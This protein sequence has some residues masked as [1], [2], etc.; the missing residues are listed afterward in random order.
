MPS[1]EPV[2]VA[3]DITT[4]V[5]TLV[6]E[7]QGLI[8]SDP[9]RLLQ[10]AREAHE[11]ARSIGDASLLGR[12][13]YWI[14]I[15]FRQA[16]DLVNA[17]LFLRQANAQLFAAYD[18]EYQARALQAIGT[19]HSASGELAEAQEC[20]VR[21]LSIARDRNDTYT[22][23]R[24][25]NSWGIVAIRSADY[26]KAFELYE[27]CLTYLRVEPDPYM[28]ASILSNIGAIYQR[29]G[30]YALAID[31]CRRALAVQGRRDDYRQ[32]A[33]V[34]IM[35]ADTLCYTGEWTEAKDAISKAI[36]IAKQHD[37]VDIEAIA[38]RTLVDIAKHAGDDT[39]S[40]ELLEE[41][42]VLSQ[43]TGNTIYLQKIEVELALAYCRRGQLA[44]A[45]A[46]L[47]QASVRARTIAS[48]QI[49]AE[50]HLAWAVY[51]RLFLRIDDALRE[52]R[53]ALEQNAVL[54]S[55]SNKIALRR[56]ER[57][58]TPENVRR[59]NTNPTLLDAI[60]E[61][62]TQLSNAIVRALQDLLIDV[63]QESLSD[64][65]NAERVARSAQSASDLARELGRV[66]KLEA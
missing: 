18:T 45:S 64:A 33:N 38:Y 36:A 10:I 41:A 16:S 54:H 13:L 48:P 40:I 56:L 39:Q 22:I 57:I 12:S 50:T 66:Q 26:A 21:A 49:L 61:E 5:R 27:E 62:Q 55:D 19:I 3:E 52:L 17:G 58:V 28:E 4:R 29:M 65:P 35:L 24:V 25:L 43:A 60:A 23:T 53:S 63:K 46:L 6:A 51:Y 59:V 2:L 20:F 34:H 14:G 47:E 32:D 11:L 8:F 42:R 15:G 31:S 9:T 1:L 37:F 44:E 7:C 30:D